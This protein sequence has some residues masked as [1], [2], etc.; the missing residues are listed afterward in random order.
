[1]VHSLGDVIHVTVYV[2]SA[3]EVVKCSGHTEHPVKCYKCSSR[4]GEGVL[5][6]RARKS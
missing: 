3:P 6:L 1:M 2:T 4:L 5:G